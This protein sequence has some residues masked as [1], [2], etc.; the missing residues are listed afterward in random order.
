MG[1]LLIRAIQNLQQTRVLAAAVV[2]VSAP[3][4]ATV[5]VFNWP[6][7][8]RWRSVEVPIWLPRRLNHSLFYLRFTRDKLHECGRALNGSYHRTIQQN[9]KKK[10]VTNQAARK[11]Q[12]KA[13]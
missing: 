12:P 11:K 9:V 2:A 10:H 7:L 5:N 8:N 4:V 3:V 13:R 6:D 1:Y